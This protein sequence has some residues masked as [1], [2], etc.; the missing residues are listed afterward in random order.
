[1]GKKKKN[2][3]EHV[4][5]EKHLLTAY[6]LAVDSA[7]MTGLSSRL[8]ET[9]RVLPCCLVN[10]QVTILSALFEALEERFDTIIYPM[11]F[12]PEHQQ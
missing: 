9:T 8:I 2:G 7:E 10:G 1:M 5:S 12:L 3:A 11:D 4:D 6:L